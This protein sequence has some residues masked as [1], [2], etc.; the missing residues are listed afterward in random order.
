MTW[1]DVGCMTG[2]MA[3]AK[4]ECCSGR[5]SGD[6]ELVLGEQEVVREDV[7]TATVIQGRRSRGGGGGGGVRR[8][9]R[10][11]RRVREVAAGGATAHGRKVAEVGSPRVEGVHVKIQVH[12]HV[13]GGC[14]RKG[15]H[16]VDSGAGMVRRRQ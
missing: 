1:R 8:A 12:V 16:A 5:G 4:D 10:T 14:R 15:Q 6:G 7:K 3:R 9:G 2:G 13:V 11:G